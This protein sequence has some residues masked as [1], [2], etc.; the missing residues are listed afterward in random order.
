MLFRS[1][2]D[3]TVLVGSITAQDVD[4]ALRRLRCWPLLVGFR[5]APAADVG[6]VVEAALALVAG[7]ARDPE[8]AEVEVNPLIVLPRGQG[9]CAVDG[10]LLP[11]TG[12]DHG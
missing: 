10:L 12:S 4:L 5:G 11:L 1:L 6:A 8:I 9:V 7:L 3:T 2:S